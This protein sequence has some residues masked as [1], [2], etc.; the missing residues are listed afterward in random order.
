MSKV[1]KNKLQE[2]ADAYL[3]KHHVVELFEVPHPP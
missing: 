2:E 3:R 1:Q